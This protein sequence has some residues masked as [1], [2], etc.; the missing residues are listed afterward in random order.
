MIDNTPFSDCH[1]T[2]YPDRESALNIF[3][4]HIISHPVKDN[5]GCHGNQS[6]D[7]NKRL[8]DNRTTNIASKLYSNRFSGQFTIL[9]L[10]ILWHIS[11]FKAT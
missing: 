4:E 9:L 1:E 10:K 7:K 5:M 3:R 8:V 6:Y 11:A 2:P